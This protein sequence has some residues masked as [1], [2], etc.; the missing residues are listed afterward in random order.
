MRLGIAN[1]FLGAGCYARKPRICPAPGFRQGVLRGKNSPT[2]PVFLVF[3]RSFLR[4]SGGFVVFLSSPCR[5]TA[6][7]RDKKI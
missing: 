4:F 3:L 7:K 1:E 5:E 2:L 6:K